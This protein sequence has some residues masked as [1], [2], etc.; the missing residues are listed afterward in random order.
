MQTFPPFKQPHC[1]KSSIVSRLL[2]GLAISAGALSSARAQS[3]SGVVTT[4]VPFLS[5][6]PDA[7]S[8]GMGELGLATSPDAQSGLF[9]LAKT[10]FT[11]A[12]SGIGLNY[13]PWLA[14]LSPG[15]YMMDAAGYHRFDTMQA[16][17]AAIRYFSLGDVDVIDYSGTQLQTAHPHEYSAELGYSRKLSDRLAIGVTF[18]YISST[19][20]NGNVNGTNYQTGTAFSGDLSLF[21]SGLDTKGQGFTAGGALT[22]LGTKI[23]YTNDAGAKDYLPANLGIGVAYTAVFDDNSKIQFGVDANKLLVPSVPSDS[24]GL[25]QYQDYS[26]TS[27]WAHSLSNSAYHFSIGAEYTFLQAFSV[28]AGYYLESAEEGNEHYL[29]AGLGLKYGIIGLNFA[30]IAPTGNGINQ[31]PLSNTV[32]FGVL[33]DL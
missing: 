20:A 11:E 27:S 1:I 4:A 12:R 15:M 3:P 5:I 16:I 10:P 30:Y 24:T 17:S 18:R 8:G 32:K 14:K 22:N 21:Y 29:T 2:L 25:T 33:L 9:N 7:R 13:T 23:G 26:I 19:L 6:N 31:D 28:R